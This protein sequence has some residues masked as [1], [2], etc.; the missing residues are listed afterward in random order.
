MTGKLVVNPD[1]TVDKPVYLLTVK[2]GQ[3]VPLA[4]LS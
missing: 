4:T 2:D 1:H 3:F